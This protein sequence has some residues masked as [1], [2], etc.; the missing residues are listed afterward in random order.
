VLLQIGEQTIDHIIPNCELMEQERD[1]LK[2]AVLRKENWPVNKYI[3][4]NKYCKSFKKFTDSLSLDKLYRKKEPTVK[5]TNQR[6]QDRDKG[7]LIETGSEEEMN[8]QTTEINTRLGERLEITKHRLR[9]PRLTI[10]NASTEITMENIATTII[11]QDPEIQTNGENI[12]AKNKFKGRKGKYN[13][14]RVWTEDT[15]TNSATQTKNRTENM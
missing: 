8:K 12:E 1:I 6:D 13:I 7:I 5:L 4:M 10:F 3:L 2:A 11:A 15:T 9:K 14:V